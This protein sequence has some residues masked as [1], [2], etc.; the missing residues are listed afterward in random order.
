MSKYETLMNKAKLCRANSLK[1]ESEW[2]GCFWLETAYKLEEQAAELTLKEA[3][4]D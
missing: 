2:A 4:N 1:A 3:K